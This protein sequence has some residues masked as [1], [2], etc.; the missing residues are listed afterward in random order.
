M[1]GGGVGR[2]G[3]G[4]SGI[5]VSCPE[6]CHPDLCVSSLG[7]KNLKNGSRRVCGGMQTSID[8]T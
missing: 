3:R 4:R 1:G 6:L 7:S 8:S 2:G 5:Q